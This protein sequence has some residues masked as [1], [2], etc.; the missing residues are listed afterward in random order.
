MNKKIRKNK[1]QKSKKKKFTVKISSKTL[2]FTLIAVCFGL[3]YLH[4]LSN[5]SNVNKFRPQKYSEHFI[6]KKTLSVSN[7]KK[8]ILSPT[9]TPI[10]SPTQAPLTGFCMRVP[11]LMYHHIQPEDTARQLGQTALTVDSGVFD[12]QMAYLAQ[13]GYATYFANDFINALITH[14][15]LSPKAVVITIDDGYEDNYI[16]ALPILQ[17]YGLKA[18]IML[19]TGLMGNSNMLSW[20]EVKSLKDSSLIY[21]TNHTWSHYAISRGPQEKIEY[22]INTAQKEIQDNTGELTNVFTY[23]YG[24]ISDNAIS[25]LQKLGY[26]GAFSEIPG[27]TQCDSFLMTLHRTR[28]GNSPLSSYGL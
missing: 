8:S 25:T 1:R 23:P 13:N 7:I 3:F 22:E 28:I 15:Q 26:I 4:N 27:Q 5:L 10:S 20:N 18:N 12:S 9:P 6:V 24:A 11:V 21:F 14:Q 17:K 2:F 16:Y 19:A